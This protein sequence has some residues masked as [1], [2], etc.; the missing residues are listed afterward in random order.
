M[1]ETLRFSRTGWGPQGGSPACEHKCLNQRGVFTLL[2]ERMCAFN[3]AVCVQTCFRMFSKLHYS[4]MDIS[5][6]D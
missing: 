6:L 2:C 1:V 3:R 4:T 5:E